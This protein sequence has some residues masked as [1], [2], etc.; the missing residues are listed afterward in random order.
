[1][2]FVN[3][4]DFKAR[5]LLTEAKL[6]QLV[7]AMTGFSAQSADIAWPL[8]TAGNIDFDGLFT[9][10]GLKTFWN[11]I[12]ADEHTDMQAAV[13][14]AEAAGG[15]CVL[16][17]PKTT[18]ETTGITGPDVGNIVIMGCGTSS[19]LRLSSAAAGPLIQTGT[20]QLANLSII[21][22]QLQGSLGAA[23]SKGVVFRRADR[24]VVRNVLFKTFLGESLTFTN[25]G[26][27]GNACTDVVVSDVVFDVGTG[28]QLF[29]D[30]LD[31]AMFTNILSTGSL[32][33]NGA[34]SLRASGASSLMRDIQ[35]DTVRVESPI[36]IGISLQSGGAAADVKW[37]SISLNNCRVFNPSSTGFEIGASGKLFA[38]VHVSH[39]QVEG[40]IPGIGFIV[41]AS[42]GMMS[43]CVAEDAVTIGLDLKASDG[44]TV[45][46]CDFVNSTV[47]GIDASATTDCKVIFNDVEGSATGVKTL[48]STTLTVGNNNGDQAPAIGMAYNR[49]TIFTTTSTSPAD[50]GYTR[51]IEG[52]T[53]QQ[54]DYFI[55]RAMG[56]AGAG[57]ANDTIT[58]KLGGVALGSLTVD[59]GVQFV[60]EWHV[61]I[62]SV[63]GASNIQVQA[64]GLGQLNAILVNRTVAT[65]DLSVNQSITFDGNVGDGGDTLTL[66]RIAVLMFADSEPA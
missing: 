60:F 54:G 61:F 11:I 16:I 28:V 7:A 26:V 42:K 4:P 12:N 36:G 53:F 5:E 21:N 50:M 52:G 8:I 23:L 56:T 63:S 39:C 34:I 24:P 19:I 51:V 14:A 45:T 55:I 15:G 57:A 9:I 31:G 44:F 30:D 48:G 6:D 43:N 64:L 27:D 38:N 58:A 22:L 35:L 13:D 59:D 2:G 47:T 49:T 65:V 29:A 1:M 40:T 20:S 17:P 33:A 3:L 10:V 62:A 46:G 66:D 41:E 37:R 25:D 18:L 32:A